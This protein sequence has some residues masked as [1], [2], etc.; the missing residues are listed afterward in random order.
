MAFEKGKSI[1]SAT[2]AD[3]ALAS[4][5]D[6]LSTAARR[7]HRYFP[8][9]RGCRARTC[10]PSSGLCERDRAGVLRS[11]RLADADLVGEGREES[12]REGRACFGLSMMRWGSG[13]GS[14]SGRWWRPPGNSWDRH[15]YEQRRYATDG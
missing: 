8:T 15:D 12:G 11:C 9:R 14:K 1:S 10:A 5:D 4:Y 13:R 7:L 2:R 3:S 6:E